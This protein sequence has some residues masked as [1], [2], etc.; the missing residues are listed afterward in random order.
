[1][2]TASRES[3]D[4]SDV[5]ILKPRRAGIAEKAEVHCIGEL[6]LKFQNANIE[7]NLRSVKRAILG[8]RSL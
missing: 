1:V 6:V 4:V 7:R 8:I 5:T 2:G 3:G